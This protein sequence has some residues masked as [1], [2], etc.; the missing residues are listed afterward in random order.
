MRVG[1]SPQE[2][3]RISRAYLALR[4]PLDP[5]RVRVTWPQL[6]SAENI[7][8]SVSDAE[9]F[10]HNGRRCGESTARQLAVASEPTASAASESRNHH[11]MGSQFCTESTVPESGSILYCHLSVL[12]HV[13]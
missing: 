12:T 10:Y 4:N 5:T 3:A 11:I 6:Q 7:A 1:T 8:P 9:T 2:Y 13:S